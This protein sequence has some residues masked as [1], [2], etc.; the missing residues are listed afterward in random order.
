MKNIILW[1]YERASWQWDVLCLLILAFIFLTPKAWFDKR[2]RPA[3]QT[4]RVIV[5]AQDYSPDKA[6]LENRV[7]ELSGNTDAEILESRE[8]K[9]ERGETFYEIDVR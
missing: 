9:N 3:N 5:Q 8:M 6:I 2:E 4:S 1:N 7:K